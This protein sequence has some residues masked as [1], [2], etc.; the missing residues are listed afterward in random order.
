MSIPQAAPKLK[1]PEIVVHLQEWKKRHDDME[2]QLEKLR[3]LTGAM[4]DC[5]LLAPIY[6][7]WDSYTAALGLIVGDKDQWMDWYRFECDMGAKPMGVRLSGG[8]EMTV[9]TIEHLAAVLAD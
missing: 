7:V 3:L 2:E 4:P 5:D 8:R 6:R 1:V 9:E